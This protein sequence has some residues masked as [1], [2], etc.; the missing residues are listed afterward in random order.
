MFFM[1]EQSGML[2]RKSIVKSKMIGRSGKSPRHTQRHIVHCPSSLG[3]VLHHR[4][5]QADLSGWEFLRV[6]HGVALTHPPLIKLPFQKCFWREGGGKWVHESFKL[7]KNMIVCGSCETLSAGTNLPDSRAHWDG[8]DH[9]RSSCEK[10]RG[11]RG[12]HKAL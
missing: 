10:G 1:T 2:S 9:F 4:S 8:R 6:V 5:L 3:Y 7:N 11:R 12:V